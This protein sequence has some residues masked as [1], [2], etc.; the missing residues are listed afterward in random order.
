MSKRVGN[1]LQEDL[2]DDSDESESDYS[3]LGIRPSLKILKYSN[4]VFDVREQRKQRAK[5]NKD[6]EIESPPVFLPNFEEK[7]V[8]KK[9]RTRSNKASSNKEINSEAIKNGSSSP[10]ANSSRPRP[11][12]TWP[13]MCEINWPKPNNN[14]KFKGFLGSGKGKEFPA[15]EMGSRY[16][17]VIP[18]FE[19]ENLNNLPWMQDPTVPLDDIKPKV[20]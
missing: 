11:T 20:L 10:R 18:E 8:K 2:Y 16:N 6:R 19:L 14:F 17:Y 3:H 15:L 1:V 9:Y 13:F 4:P 5:D 7:E 12:P